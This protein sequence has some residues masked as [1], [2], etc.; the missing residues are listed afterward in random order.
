MS[1][2]GGAPRP[3][4]YRSPS[5]GLAYLAGSFLIL[6]FF[7]SG[8][9]AQTDP[10][11]YYGGDIETVAKNAEIEA[12]EYRELVEEQRCNRRVNKSICIQ[13]VHGE[14]RGSH[15]GRAAQEPELDEN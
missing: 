14:C 13:E 5:A 10:Y 1:V 4:A 2:T 11:S 3:G 15:S 6:T 8:A 7:C 12:C 9:S